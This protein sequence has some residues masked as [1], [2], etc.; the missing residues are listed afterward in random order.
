MQ[1][2]R[3]S[4][5]A[6]ARASKPPQTL[7]ISLCST[8]KRGPQALEEV[9]ALAVFLGSGWHRLG[10]AVFYSRC[11]RSFQVP[12]KGDPQTYRRA[13]RDGVAVA[14][15]TIA[16]TDGHR[17]VEGLEFRVAARQVCTLFLST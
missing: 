12:Q 15:K 14:Q 13:E 4:H 9:E 11:L 2:S 1:I 8:K 5:K 10:A 17:R 6:E 7:K 16:W 3:K